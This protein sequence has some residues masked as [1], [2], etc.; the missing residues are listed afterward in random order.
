MRYNITKKNSTS[1]ERIL[2]E[3]LKKLKIPFRHRW[4][5][6]GRE[7]DFL[8]GK[9]A[10]E[11]D[12]HAQDEKKTLSLYRSGYIPI[13]LPNKALQEDLTYLEVWLKAI[14]N[15]RMDS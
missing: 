8:I 15:S 13:H 6:N 12:G 4:I 5:I 1:S 2:Y 14:Q 7:I 3:I 11:L 10:I 9:Y